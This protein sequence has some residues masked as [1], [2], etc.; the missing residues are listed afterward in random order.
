MARRNGKI[1]LTG[2]SGFPKSLDVGKSI[3][4]AAG[5]EREVVGQADRKASL[6]SG[7][8]YNTG[9][10]STAPTISAPA[11]D[12]AKQW[13]GWGTALKPALEPITLA[14]KPLCGTVAANVQ[15]HGT[16]ALN[17]DGCRVGTEVMTESRMTQTSGGVLNANGR[18]VENGNW[19]QTP[20]DNPAQHTGRWPA[21]LLHDGSP[22]VLAGFPNSNS[23]K[24][25]RNIEYGQFEQKDTNSIYAAGLNSSTPNRAPIG[26][27][28]SAARFF[29]CGKATK[30]DRDE[31]LEGFELG[32]PPA[33][34]RSTPAPGRENALGN[35]RA[36]SHPTVKPTAVMRWLC[37]L[38]TPP[39]GVV[40]DPFTGSG[41]T[42]K[43]AIYEGF[44]CVGIE[45]EAE[46]V[47]IAKARC[48]RAVH[49]MSCKGK[50]DSI[51]DLP[52]FQNQI[53]EMGERDAPE[54]IA[55]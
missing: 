6:G 47:E 10:D 3:D 18:D 11:T 46:Y 30:K 16:G 19:K 7:G 29:Y 40:L 28:G 33:S 21:N 17:I 13:D 54:L 37:R 34:A 14:R 4:K 50:Q 53:L 24:P 49:D 45:R 25:S 36:N 22:D 9:Q 55:Q 44:Q 39:G 12:A 1:F 43:A 52:L 23:T 35:P 48:A 41:S 20:N 31:G 51:T 2:N 32:P 26:D 15:Q 5:A 8:R 42:L 38:I 27:T